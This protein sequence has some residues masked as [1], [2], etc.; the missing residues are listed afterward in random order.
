MGSKEPSRVKKP[1]PATVT[2]PLPTGSFEFPPSGSQ[3][4]QLEQKVFVGKDVFEDVNVFV[5]G[6]TDVFVLVYVRVKVLVGTV[7]VFAAVGGVALWETTHP[8][9]SVTVKPKV[10]TPTPIG[11]SE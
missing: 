1:M 10:D 2:P 6:A 11:L 4:L 3:P 5:G 9:S 7:G 8:L